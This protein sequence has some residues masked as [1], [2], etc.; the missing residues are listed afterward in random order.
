MSARDAAPRVDR[1]SFLGAEWRR[2]V[3]LNYEIDS[4]VLAPLVPAGTTL[5]LW[6]GGALVSVVGF[7][8][9]KTRVCGVPVPFHRDFDEVNLR[10]YVR[11]TMADG[12]V[13]RGVTFV[14]EL[15]PRPAIAWLAR[16]LYDEPYLA[17]PMQHAHEP[18]ANG[19]STHTGYEW[20]DAG[21]WQGMSAVTSGEPALPA[22]GSEAAF[23]VEHYWGYTRRRD[24]GTTE[25]AVA[26]APWRVWSAH[27]SRLDADA[28]QLWGAVFV[29]ALTAPPVSALVAEGSPI[30]V[31]W[32]RPLDLAGAHA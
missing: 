19:T 1:G 13:R 18:I 26:H 23:V 2:L 6:N 17:V 7:R 28:T 21:R 25:Y 9:L 4:A 30:T 3:M 24:G 10:F 8:F 22:P 32:P 31:G 5:D 29:P 27:E 15:V 16:M 12:T 14:R 20:R 11:R